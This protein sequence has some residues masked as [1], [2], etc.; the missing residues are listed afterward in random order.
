MFPVKKPKKKKS[1]KKKKKKKKQQQKKQTIIHDLEHSV[2]NEGKY[3]VDNC[4]N[5]SKRRLNNL[6]QF[7]AY[8]L[9]TVIIKLT[10]KTQ[11]YVWFIALDLN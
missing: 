3:S 9:Q 11:L 5:C 6:N 10:V 1:K 2:N 7:G 8:N 4:P